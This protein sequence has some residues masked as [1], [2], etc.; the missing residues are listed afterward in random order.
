M[1]FGEERI[2]ALLMTAREEAVCPTIGGA[3]AAALLVM[4]RRIAA[5]VFI[6]KGYCL[7]QE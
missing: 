1:V 4:A 7:E 3:K 2:S 6:F 5:E